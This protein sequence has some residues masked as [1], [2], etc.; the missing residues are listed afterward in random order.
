MKVIMAPA[1][2]FCKGVDNAVRKAEIAVEAQWRGQ[3]V[4]NIMPLPFSPEI[5]GSSPLWSPTQAIFTLLVCLQTPTL[6]SLLSTLHILGQRVQ[7]L[8]SSINAILRL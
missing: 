3:P 7:E 6:P 1:L 5:G 8:Y 4:K 2:G